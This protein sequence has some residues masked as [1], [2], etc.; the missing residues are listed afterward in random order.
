MLV[1]YVIMI[2]G[3]GI[4][5]YQYFTM[6]KSEK[7]KLFYYQWKKV[8]TEEAISNRAKRPTSLRNVIP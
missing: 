2:I 6:K 7:T 4:Q 8:T 3:M 5:I 1:E